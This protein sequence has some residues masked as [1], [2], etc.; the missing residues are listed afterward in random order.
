MTRKFPTKILIPTKFQCFSAKMSKT[1]IL[2]N[3][4]NYYFY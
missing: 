2:Q 4:K 3:N 1:F